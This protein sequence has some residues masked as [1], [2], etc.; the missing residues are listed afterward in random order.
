MGLGIGKL[1]TGDPEDII[2]VSKDDPILKKFILDKSE[3]T[4]WDRVKFV[5]QTE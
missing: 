2:P 5:F 1:I 3:M 4:G